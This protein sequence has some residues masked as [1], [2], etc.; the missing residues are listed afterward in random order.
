MLERELDRYITQ[1]MEAL[2]EL[3]RRVDVLR[4]ESARRMAALTD[5]FRLFESLTGE[6]HA[7]QAQMFRGR[8]GDGRLH[9]RMDR[10]LASLDRARG[11]M[12][13]TDIVASMPDAPERGAVTA[14]LHR[15]VKRGEAR[16]LRRGVYE[17]VE[18]SI[19]AVPSM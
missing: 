6:L 1:E 16:R 13:V 9:P 19:K 3:K 7:A 18:S 12:T 2:D 14:A 4:L 10:I 17:R 8:S 11:P 15:A 5:S